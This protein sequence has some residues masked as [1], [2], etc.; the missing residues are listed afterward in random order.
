M[1]FRN[2]LILLLVLA[3]LAAYVLLVEVKRPSPETSVTPSATPMTPLLSFDKATVRALRLSAPSRGQ[4]TELVYESDGK[5]YIKVPI[6]EEADQSEIDLIIGDLAE[7]RPQRA[8]SE[9]LSSLA[10]YDLD[11]PSIV[12]EIE[13]Q[14]TTRT[15][16]VGAQDAIGSGYYAQVDG[17][18]RLWLIPYYV[19]SELERVLNTPPVKPTP[20]ASPTQEATIEPSPSMTPSP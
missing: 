14:D 15:L 4:R 11:P 16:K 18:E 17:D 13:L 19:G 20:T 7:L 6:E 2:T 3:A 8:L 10:D 9:P 12:V 5:W 1:R